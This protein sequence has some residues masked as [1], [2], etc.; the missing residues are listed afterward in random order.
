M[1]KNNLKLTIELVPK[2]CWYSN[3]RSN[4]TKN[5]WDIIRKKSYELANNQCEICGDVGKNQ[6][7]NHNV[8]CHEIWEY[9]DL[10]KIQKLIGLIS[11]CPYCH[12]TKHAG[13]AQMNGE[14]NI[15][16]NQLIKVNN[17][18][19]KDAIDYINDSFTIWRERS[20]H[21]WTLDISVLNQYL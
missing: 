19:R 14:E 21:E 5:E 11:L 9:D 8:E 3:V 12:K 18:T 10:D 15:V 20:K 17:I 2:T 13:L 1:S 6:G 16:I 7:V 4:V